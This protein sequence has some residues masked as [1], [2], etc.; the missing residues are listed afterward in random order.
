MLGEEEQ[1]ALDTLCILVVRL[2]GAT[3]LCVLWG[4]S[5]A[6]EHMLSRKTDI[7]RVSFQVKSS[8]I[9]WTYSSAAERDF[10]VPINSCMGMEKFPSFWDAMT[11]LDTKLWGWVEDIES[12]W[13]VQDAP[14][15]LPSPERFSLTNLWFLG[16]TA[17]SWKGMGCL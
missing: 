2:R 3:L 7:I 4:E 14:G 13:S 8:G 5:V 15:S 1:I 10:S 16:M 17:L 11:N 6:A 9:A 12:A